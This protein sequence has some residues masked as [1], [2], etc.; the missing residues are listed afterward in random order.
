MIFLLISILKNMPKMYQLNI[1]AT[2]KCQLKFWLPLI[3]VTH[4]VWF[5]LIIWIIISDFVPATATTFKV[6]MSPWTNYT[7]RVIGRNKVGDSLPSGHSKVCLTP[8]DVPYK[9]P[10]NV[11]GRGHAPNNIVI[12]WT[13]CYTI[14][15]S[16]TISNNLNDLIIYILS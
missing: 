16:L 2:L 7:F 4:L 13:V 9:N 3:Y 5:D 10:D 12:S 11:M 1:F 8:E 6:A 14:I 15:T